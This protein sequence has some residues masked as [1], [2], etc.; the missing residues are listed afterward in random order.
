M[1][2]TDITK[3]QINLDDLIDEIWDMAKPKVSGGITLADL[4]ASGQG[5]TIIGVLIDAQ[6]FFQYDQREGNV[7][8]PFAFDDYNKY[9]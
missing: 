8:D 2:K 6:L 9:F 1:T 5:G 3:L 4:I 7:D